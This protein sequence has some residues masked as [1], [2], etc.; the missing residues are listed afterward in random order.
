MALREFLASLEEATEAVETSSTGLG[1][2]EIWYSVLILFF[3]RATLQFAL[4][5]PEKYF[6]AFGHQAGLDQTFHEGSRC[7]LYQ[8]ML[9]AVEHKTFSQIIRESKSRDKVKL[10]PI[11]LSVLMFGEPLRNIPG[12]PLFNVSIAHLLREIIDSFPTTRW[13]VGDLIFDKALY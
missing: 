10:L 7:Q 9:Q 6:R 8:P 1:V 4:Q 3:I 5:Y 12:A 13:G 11:D 2:L